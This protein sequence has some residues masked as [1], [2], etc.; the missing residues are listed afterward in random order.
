MGI[1]SPVAITMGGL[2]LIQI[3]GQLGDANVSAEYQWE[4]LVL[5][6]AL[7]LLAG[8]SL[9]GRKDLGL[10]IPSVL[11]GIVLLLLSSR[12]LTSLMGVDT[13]QLVP[14]FS[15]ELSWLVPVIS[16]EVLLTPSIRLKVSSIFE[17]PISDMS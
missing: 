14:T 12:V 16:L 6:G 17:S 11:E 10:R 8:I 3:A 13:I 7:I 2:T 1:E 4:V 9:L 5:L 15:D